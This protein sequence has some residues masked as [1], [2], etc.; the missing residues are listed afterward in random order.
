M[1]SNNVN[2][3]ITILDY[4]DYIKNIDY[5]Q[6]ACIFDI[7]L[8][9]FPSKISF[10]IFN[11]IKDE[12]DLDNDLTGDMI[13][14]MEKSLSKYI[15]IDRLIDYSESSSL[16]LRFSELFKLGKLLNRLYEI[17][18]YNENRSES[19]IENEISSFVESTIMH[20]IYSDV[21]KLKNNLPDLVFSDV[22][23]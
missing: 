18:Y 20:G 14:S 13:L 21:E 1:N 11:Q 4:D 22:E 2:R 3:Y 23:E 9:R 12:L 17:C 16:I 15:E 10:V 7:F 19:D 5:Y 8:T 6:N